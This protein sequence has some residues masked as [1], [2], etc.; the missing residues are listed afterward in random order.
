V[1]EKT[2]VYMRATQNPH[3]STLP[4]NVYYESQTLQA[5]EGIGISNIRDAIGLLNTE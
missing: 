1:N 5:S 3:F 2:I 4:W